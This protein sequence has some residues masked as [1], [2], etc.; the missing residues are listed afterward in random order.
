MK[1][2]EIDDK[3]KKREEELNDE[4][5]KAKIDREEARCKELEII[6]S[7][8]TKMVNDLENDG[9]KPEYII[10]EYLDKEADIQSQ[11]EVLEEK[12]KIDNMRVNLQ[13]DDIKQIQLYKTDVQ[14][15]ARELATTLSISVEDLME[16]SFTLKK[17]SEGMS[18]KNVSSSCFSLI[19]DNPWDLGIELLID[20]CMHK[21]EPKGQ[22]LLESSSS[23][24]EM[25]DET[26][27]EAKELSSA[28]ERAKLQAGLNNL[29]DVDGV[30]ET[31]RDTSAANYEF[32]LDYNSIR[33]KSITESFKL[34]KDINVD[35]IQKD[36]T[37]AIENSQN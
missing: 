7:Q 24:L 2:K 16:I 17:L 30:I 29:P 12:V 14:K 5:M 35:K 19:F 27:A 23:I 37:L 26:R 28:K 33:K 13:K 1:I 21:N 4:F 15:Q 36:A 3:I 8:C 6:K 22:L 32:L 10:K 9:K 31:I 25:D 18:M 11:I 20:K 34:L